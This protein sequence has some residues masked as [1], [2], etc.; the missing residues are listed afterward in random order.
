MIF[1]TPVATGTHVTPSPANSIVTPLVPAPAE[2]QRMVWRLPRFHAVPG[3]GARNPNP[4]MVYS[5]SE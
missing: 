3:S 5:P 2:S 4:A 1:V